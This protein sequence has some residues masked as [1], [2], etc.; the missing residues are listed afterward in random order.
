MDATFG[1]CQELVLAPQA[2]AMAGRSGAAA[3]EIEMR[4]AVAK[5]DARAMAAEI[6]RGGDANSLSAQAAAS[7]LEAAHGVKPQLH[8][9][10][11]ELFLEYATAPAG[12]QLTKHDIPADGYGIELQYCSEGASGSGCTLIGVSMYLE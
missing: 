5:F 1:L 8:Q 11:G 3:L 9:R 4:E 7:A 10:E 12:A 6:R 2:F